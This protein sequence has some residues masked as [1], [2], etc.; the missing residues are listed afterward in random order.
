M[1]VDTLKRVIKRLRFLNKPNIKRG[2]LECA[3]IRE[4]GYSRSTYIRVKGVLIKLGWLRSEKGNRF[5][6]T[7]KDLEE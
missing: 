2:E 7:G 6:L 3:I 4:C 1:A 5:H